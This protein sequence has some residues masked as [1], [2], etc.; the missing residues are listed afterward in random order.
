M[1][2]QP[3]Q[4]YE[5]MSL[6]QQPTTVHPQQ[7][8]PARPF[9]EPPADAHTLVTAPNDDSQF[10]APL[11]RMHDKSGDNDGPLRHGALHRTP[12]LP[13]NLTLQM[14]YPVNMPVINPT[15]NMLEEPHWLDNDVALSCAQPTQPEN[16]HTGMPTKRVRKPPLKRDNAELKSEIV[17]RLGDKSFLKLVLQM[18][19]LVE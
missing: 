17:A 2:Q 4:P 16:A 19:S 5:F 13:P 11:L 8:F 14:Q 6:Q 3:Q 7:P 10:L 18:D 15:K 9:Y 1:S 12:N